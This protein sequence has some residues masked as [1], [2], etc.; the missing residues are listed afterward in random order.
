MTDNWWLVFPCFN[1]PSHV[2]SF[3]LHS[4]YTCRTYYFFIATPVFMGY[5]NIPPASSSFPNLS[6]A[7][8]SQTGFINFSSQFFASC[9]SI[10]KYNLSQRL[11]GDSNIS[12]W[13]AGAS[14]DKL[15]QVALQHIIHCCHQ[16]Y[17]LLDCLIY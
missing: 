14:G 1:N 15:L 9:I 2:L 13:F 3:P 8:T 11:A 17:I 10:L 12:I 6:L 4:I 16:T 7:T 5:A